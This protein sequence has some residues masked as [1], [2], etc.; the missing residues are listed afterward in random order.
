MAS[1]NTPIQYST[2]SSSESNQARKRNKWYSNRKVGSQIV[3]VSRRH[4]SIPRR[5]HR[6]SPK[7]PETD[8]QFQQ[9]LRI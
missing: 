5:P 7:T 4:D 6:L 8:K 3:S 2:G 1:L 9:S